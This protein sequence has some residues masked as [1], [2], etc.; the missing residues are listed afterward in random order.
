MR[1]GK[2]WEVG[3]NKTLPR[4]RERNDETFGKREH[5]RPVVIPLVVRVVPIA[6]HP[7]TVVIPIGVEHVRVAVRVGLYKAP[8]MPLPFE[9]SQSCIEFRIIMR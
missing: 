6:V 8:S 7:L 3:Q 5:E 2:C 4:E 1:S 9:Y